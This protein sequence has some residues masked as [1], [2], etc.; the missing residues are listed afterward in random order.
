[1]INDVPVNS[2]DLHVEEQGEGEMHSLYFFLPIL[3]CKA[4]TCISS[5]S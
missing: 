4:Y 5:L 2:L 1:M 3:K